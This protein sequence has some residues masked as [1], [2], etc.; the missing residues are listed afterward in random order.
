[1]F[2]AIKQLYDHADTWVSGAE[3]QICGRSS[4]KVM[5]TDV[6][7]VRDLVPLNPPHK[8]IC[9]ALTPH[10]RGVVVRREES[11]LRCHPRLLSEAQNYKIRRQ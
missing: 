4:L 6:V 9:R 8:G 10:W 7:W 2:I 11:R 3:I 1:M 5:V